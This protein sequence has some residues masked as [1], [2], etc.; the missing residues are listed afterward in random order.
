MDKESFLKY[1]I[2][3]PHRF[4]E[5]CHR[6][7]P[8]CE[9]SGEARRNY[10]KSADQAPYDGYTHGLYQGF[11][12]RI[13]FEYKSSSNRSEILAD[14]LGDNKKKGKLRSAAEQ[15]PKSPTLFILVS[16]AKIT[17]Q[18][19]RKVETFIK[20]NALPF[21]FEGLTLDPPTLEKW[22]ERQPDLALKFRPPSAAK[23]MEDFIN[24][25][26]AQ[27]APVDFPQYRQLDRVYEPPREYNRIFKTLQKKKIVFIVG[28]PHVG[29]TF[30]AAQLLLRFYRDGREPRWVLPKELKPEP[31]QPGPIAFQ[32]KEPKES[33]VG[34]I[35]ENVGRDKITYVEDIFGRTSQEETKWKRADLSPREILR[36][37]V[38]LVQRDEPH[39]LVI[40]T[41]REKI[42][43]RA[44]KAAPELKELVI[45]LKSRVRVEPG[46]YRLTQ[47]K[48]MLLNYGKLYSCGWLTGSADQLPREAVQYGRALDTPQAIHYF[49]KLSRAATSAQ[50]LGKYFK[51]AKQE[52]VEAYAH[53]IRELEETSLA[54]LLVGE[55]LEPEPEIFAA[56]FPRLAQADPE[57]AM[58]CGLENIRDRVMS[59][60]RRLSYFHPSYPE[61]IAL[62]LEAEPVRGLF[63]EMCSNLAGSRSLSFRSLSA[64]ALSRNFRNLDAE[65]REIIRSM[66]HDPQKAV[67]GSAA[68]ALGRHFEKLN[69]KDREVFCSLARDFHEVVRASAADALVCNINNLNE[70]GREILRSLVLDPQ[71]VVRNIAILELV[72]NFKNLN[73]EGREILHSLAR[74]PQEGVRGKAAWALGRNF[75]NLKQEG[76][77]ILRSL[78]KDHQEAVRKNA[79]D[80]LGRNFENLD[81]EGRKML[82]SLAKDPSK[83]VREQVAQALRSLPDQTN[84]ELQSILQEIES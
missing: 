48:K 50:E 22:L 79:A 47:K 3:D 23:T 40:V 18:S 21:R 37:L 64:E 84:E 72:W 11:S 81:A 62:S 31:W 70:E 67:R 45:R 19:I 20:T 66:A 44:L 80:A 83:K 75:E 12:G 17:H 26:K 7:I 15:R 34:L 52:L 5:F 10:N 82:S 39:A 43:D 59:M 2:A 77:E 49:C 38:E 42:F 41:S 9:L 56:A 54:A 16:P 28:P 78:A 13:V 27:K 57:Q 71:K 33:L 1:L 32:V 8:A 29:K 53:E 6:A 36:H 51:T 55:Y 65:G 76:C 46:S 61:A 25:L 69:E 74:D 68:W 60:E 35:K 14:L 73:E 24:I 4:E 30:T 63:K 58:A